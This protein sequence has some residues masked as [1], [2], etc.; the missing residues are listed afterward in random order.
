MIRKEEY[1][2]L[3]DVLGSPS[4]AG[5]V[6]AICP[7]ESSESHVPLGLSADRF[8]HR[9]PAFTL[10]RHFSHENEKADTHRLDL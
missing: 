1:S 6:M 3:N 2:Q 4:I 5:Y 10:D 9:V 8:G 7:A